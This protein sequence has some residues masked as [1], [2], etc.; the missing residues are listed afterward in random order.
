MSYEARRFRALASVENG[1]DGYLRRIMREDIEPLKGDLEELMQ[2]ELRAITGDPEITMKE[3][4]QMSA[5]V[6]RAASLN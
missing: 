2:I 1:D 3:F 4:Y 5:E 6:R